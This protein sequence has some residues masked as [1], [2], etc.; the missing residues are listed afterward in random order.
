MAESRSRLD[1]GFEGLT[2][3]FLGYSSCSSG[4]EYHHLPS[5]NAQ[6]SEPSGI[7]AG[8]SHFEGS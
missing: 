1:D 7:H 3:D 5:T 4:G 2:L 8:H 6:G